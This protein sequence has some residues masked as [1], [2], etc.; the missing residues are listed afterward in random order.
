MLFIVSCVLPLLVIIIVNKYD[1]SV[2]FQGPVR[3]FASRI[4]EET[5]DVDT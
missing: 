4:D 3:G 1:G 5:R 2:Q